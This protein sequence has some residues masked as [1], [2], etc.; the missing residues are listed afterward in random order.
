MKYLEFLLRAYE[1]EKITYEEQLSNILK[2]K[3]ARLDDVRTIVERLHDIVNYMNTVEGLI[4]N[5][6]G[7]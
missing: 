3:S 6:K 1:L 4:K 7:E 5:L 2:D